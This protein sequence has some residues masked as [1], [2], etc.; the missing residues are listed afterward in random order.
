MPYD[1][2]MVLLY[3]EFTSNSQHRYSSTSVTIPGGR[4]PPTF[5]APLLE[6]E[7]KDRPSKI[8]LFG[9]SKTTQRPQKV[10]KGRSKRQVFHTAITLQMSK[11][12]V[13]ISTVSDPSGS[14]RV[15]M[16]PG[17]VAAARAAVATGA[18]G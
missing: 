1:I 16:L 5:R 10:Q 3:N 18:L 13:A 11:F 12:R 15:G 9:T 14:G 8:A 17:P 2:T 6:V 7:A 4:D